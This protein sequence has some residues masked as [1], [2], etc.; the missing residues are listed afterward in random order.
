VRHRPNKTLA[1]A[2]SSAPRARL[3]RLLR[4]PELQA[5]V[6]TASRLGLRA[7]LVGGAVRD[8]LLA[9]AVAEHD[10]AV[11]NDPDRM[12]EAL[13]AAGFGTTVL[14]S[15]Q[16]PRVYRVA[17][18]RDLDIA[19]IAGGSIEADLARRDFTVNAIACTLPDGDLIDPFG[20]IED[21]AARRLRAV[22]EKNLLDDP[23]RVLRAARLMATHGLEPDRELTEGSRRAASGLTGAAGERVRTELVKL[24]AS[25]RVAGSLAWLRSAGALAPVLAFDAA[26]ARRCSRKQDL[27][28]LDEASVRR[29]PPSSRVP[30]RLALIADRA[31]LS[32]SEAGAWLR[33]RR[34]SRSEAGEVA[35]LLELA[36]RAFRIRSSRDEWEWIGDAGIRRTDAA[37]LVS[38]LRPGWRRLANR[39]GRPLPSRRVRVRGS[40]LLAWLAIPPGPMVGRLL[41]EVEVEILR[42]AIRSKRDARR[43][44]ALRQTGRPRRSKS[45]RPKV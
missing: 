16:N 45:R 19:Q 22:S 10:L 28:R 36:S 26:R 17:G 11:S 41:R 31:G 14:L 1:P 37:T 21:L 13:T 33:S 44:L 27:L 40:D 24:L 25:E 30:I 6:R 43:W 7:W 8:I 35:A 39:L 20:G 32:P 42:G 18:A 9:R 5:A 23:L 34:F 2:L 15:D 38:V 29:T 3:R 4:R 12:A